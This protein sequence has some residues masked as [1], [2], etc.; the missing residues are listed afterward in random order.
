V[1]S[2]LFLLVFVVSTLG[3]FAQSIQN[4][5]LS[6]RFNYSD[7][8]CDPKINR[9]CEIADS[10]LSLESFWQQV[11]HA[12]DQEIT[13]SR[14]TM[15]RLADTL[16]R[17]KSATVIESLPKQDEGVTT[18]GT[19]EANHTR[20]YKSGYDQS[21]SDLALTIIHEWVHSVDYAVNPK[22]LQFAH[23]RPQ[24]PSWNKNTASYRIQKIA[25]P[26]LP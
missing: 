1:N 10:V 23:R 15:D 2:K 5:Y 20:I 11:R 3:C 6:Q 19:S 22:K 7:V 18:A 25:K 26:F 12:K 13:N 21:T 14:Y 16:Q 4:C 8:P 9:S 24:Y 17:Y